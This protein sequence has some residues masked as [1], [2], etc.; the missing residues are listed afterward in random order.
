MLKRILALVRRYAVLA[1][2]CALLLF[3]V[4]CD[5]S[6]MP[7]SVF[8]DPAGP[9]HAGHGHGR[10]ASDHDHDHDHEH[11]HASGIKVAWHEC[12]VVDDDDGTSTDLQSMTPVSGSIDGFQAI[13]IPS[14]DHILAAFDHKRTLDQRTGKPLQGTATPPISPPPR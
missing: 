9:E 13:A 6:P 11:H 12:E 3:P 2:I 7:H 5:A 10:T 4:T 14:L 1:P 8:I